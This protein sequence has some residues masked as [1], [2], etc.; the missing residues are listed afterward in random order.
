MLDKAVG[1]ENLLAV[2]DVEHL[3]LKHKKKKCNESR[4]E[5]KA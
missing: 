4:N 5:D 3:I 1:G 2:G